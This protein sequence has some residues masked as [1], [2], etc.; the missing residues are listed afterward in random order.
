MKKSIVILL[1]LLIVSIGIF[2][3]RNHIR[4]YICKYYKVKTSNVE[5]ISSTDEGQFSVDVYNIKRTFYGRAITRVNDLFS[6][7]ILVVK[8]PLGNHRLNNLILKPVGN[9]VI[10]SNADFYFNTL[11]FMEDYKPMKGL[12]SNKEQIGNKAPK[13]TRMGIDSKGNITIFN[14]GGN[15]KY[16]DVLQAPFTFKTTS[17]VKNNFNTVNF[18]QFISIK[19]NKLVYISSNGNSLIAWKDVQSVLVQLDISQV[20]ALDGGAS[21]DYYFR[22]KNIYSFS[23]IPFRNLWFF[24]NSPYYIEGY[25]N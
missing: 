14:N 1:P 15:S 3:F 13:K 4:L 5:L 25:L 6:D 19:D 9:D 8:I 22:G 23:S 20:I 10:S 21:F 11:F 12:I 16:K 7:Q 17:K 2:S 24:K 18:R